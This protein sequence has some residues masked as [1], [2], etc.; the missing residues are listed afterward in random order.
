MFTSSSRPQRQPVTEYAVEIDAVPIERWRQSATGVPFVRSFNSGKPGPHVLIT[1][2]THGNEIA[3]A[4][5]L[6]RLLGSGL[7]PTKGRLSLAFA[8]VDAYS[9]FSANDPRASRWVDED[10]NRVWSPEIL[11]SQPARS[12]DAARAAELEPIVADADYL[13]DLHTTQHHNEPLVLAGPLERSR[14]LAMT[15]GLANLVVVDKGHAQGPRM[16]DYGGVGDPS[17]T[18]TALLIE[19]GQPWAASSVETAY[20][21]CIR[22]L[23]RLELLPEDAGLQDTTRLPQSAQRIVEIAMPVTIKHEFT[24]AMP[25]RGGEVLPKAGTVIGH[26]GEEPVRTPYDD[27]VVIMPSQRL[28]SGLTAV[29]LGRDISATLVAPVYT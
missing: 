17:R 21:A 8:N 4:V 28:W 11:H 10:M 6:D 12:R 18:N 19:A 3:G 7:H 13:L 2:L 25:L 29:R 24:F 23:C 27:C 9:K 26:H 16:R 1:A 15:M 14:I 5:A 22:F 20:A